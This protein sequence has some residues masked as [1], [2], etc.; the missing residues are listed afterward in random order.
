MHYLRFIQLILGLATISM[1]SGC[2][3]ITNSPAPGCVTSIDPLMGGCSGKTILSHLN[4]TPEIACLNIGVNNCNGGILEIKNSCSHDFKVAGITIRPSHKM[5]FDV[6]KKSSSDTTFSLKE[7]DGNFSRYQVKTNKKISFSALL[8]TK[9]VQV[10]FTKTA[11][12]C[13]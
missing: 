2:F 3:I 7:S 8:G 10:S 13:E 9:P 6:V 5:S 1:L 11:P 4:V 12:L